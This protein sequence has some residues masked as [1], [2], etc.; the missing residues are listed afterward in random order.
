MGGLPT[1]GFPAALSP[2]DDG[3]KGTSRRW[4]ILALGESGRED[5]IAKESVGECGR[6]FGESTS[7]GQEGFSKVRCLGMSPVPDPAQAMQQVEGPTVLGPSQR[8]AMLAAP[9][10]ALSEPECRQQLQDKRHLAQASGR[11]FFFLFSLECVLLTHRLK[12][13]V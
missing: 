7:R 9:R 10:G 2:R 12:A 3:A 8:Q 13:S 1:P 11:L 4:G 5:G 6:L